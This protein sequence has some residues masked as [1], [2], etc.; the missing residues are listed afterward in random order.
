M[1]LFV[2]EIQMKIILFCEFFFFFS[3]YIS[4]DI[5]K[6]ANTGERFKTFFMIGGENLQQIITFSIFT[7]RDQLSNNF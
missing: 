3:V 4:N 7:I 5:Y 2:V 1:I 6:Y